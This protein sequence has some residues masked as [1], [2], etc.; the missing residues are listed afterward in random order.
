MNQQQLCETTLKMNMK[1]II[2]M[3]LYFSNGLNF[4]THFKSL[5]NSFFMENIAMKSLEQKRLRYI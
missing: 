1:I 4:E 2:M 3:M 5:I